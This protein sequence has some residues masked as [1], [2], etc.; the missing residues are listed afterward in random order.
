M[1]N[2]CWFGAEKDR[3]IKN[4]KEKTVVLPNFMG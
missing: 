4:V 1:N 2:G 3:P